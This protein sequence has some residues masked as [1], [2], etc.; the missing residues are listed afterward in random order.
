MRETLHVKAAAGFRLSGDMQLRQF[1]RK[2]I[3]KPMFNPEYFHAEY[4]Q[5]RKGRS[6]RLRLAG[7]LLLI[8]VQV[9]VSVELLR[10]I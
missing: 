4:L 5:K 8:A 3:Q 6:Q 7:I 2:Q 1:C 10:L 9:V